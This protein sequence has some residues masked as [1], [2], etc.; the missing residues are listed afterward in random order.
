[1]IWAKIC[2]NFFFLGKSSNQTPVFKLTNQFD[3][4]KS[5]KKCN[6]KITVNNHFGFLNF[7]VKIYVMY[8]YELYK[9]CLLYSNN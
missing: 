3:Q 8:L 6:Y 1:M 5:T 4:M 9:Y 2:P 7:K